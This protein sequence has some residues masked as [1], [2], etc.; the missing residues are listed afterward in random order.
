MT[1]KRL[2]D[3]RGA[4]K[5]FTQEAFIGGMLFGAALMLAF[6]WVVILYEI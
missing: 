2:I 4:W 6:I 5:Y 3:V 1:S